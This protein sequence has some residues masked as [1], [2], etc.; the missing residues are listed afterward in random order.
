MYKI[1][2]IDYFLD[3]FHARNYPLWLHKQ[4]NGQLNVTCAYAMAESPHDGMSNKQWSETYQIPLLPTI[5]DVIEQSDGIMVLSP[6]HPEMHESL[7]EKAFKSGKRIYVDKAFA[8]DLQTARKMFHL[9]EQYQTP[10][11]SASALACM[12]SYE[13]IATEKLHILSSKGPGSFAVYAIHQLEPIIKLMKDEPVRI[14]SVG[15]QDFPSFLIE[16]P[17]G[18]IAKSEQFPT[19]EFEL[20][21]GYTDGT[22]DCVKADEALFDPFI[23]KV[24][25]FFQTGQL[26]AEHQQTLVVIALLDAAKTALENPLIWIDIAKP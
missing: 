14:M 7:C 13:T 18:K 24:I 22:S 23:K 25:D 10:C 6:S 4:S 3:N 11:C 17:D 12:P 15:T 16:F 9:A 5:E 21:A 20:Y 1:G 26:I 2:F 19:A 8:P